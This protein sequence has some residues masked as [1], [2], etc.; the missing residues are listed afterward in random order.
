MPRSIRPND[1]IFEHE[2]QNDAEEKLR[3]P[4]FCRSFTRL[5]TV[6]MQLP[7]DLRASTRERI[8]YGERPIKGKCG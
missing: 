4:S 8:T 7:V 3:P 5:Q 6:F 2:K 1:A